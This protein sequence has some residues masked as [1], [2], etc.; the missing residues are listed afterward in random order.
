MAN[1]VTWF[2]IACSDF[3]RA[4]RFYETIFEVALQDMSPLKKG[5]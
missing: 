4:K 5:S 3:D 1:A 2:E